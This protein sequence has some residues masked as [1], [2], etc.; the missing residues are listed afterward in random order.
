MIP[1]FVESLIESTPELRS[2]EVILKLMLDDNELEQ[3]HKH[4]LLLIFTKTVIQLITTMSTQTSEPS[5]K[6]NNVITFHKY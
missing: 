5:I 6:G 3:P 1:K 4:I 2:F